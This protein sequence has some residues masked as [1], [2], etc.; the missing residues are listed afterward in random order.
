[1]RLMEKP[2]HNHVFPCDYHRVLSLLENH[3]LPVLGGQV[4]M[5][6]MNKKTGNTL[7][8]AYR[9]LCTL[10]GWMD[11]TGIGAEELI[12]LLQAVRK[13]QDEREAQLA[14][15]GKAVFEEGG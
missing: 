8:L 10:A 11:R 2:D 5:K 7:F 4:D 12:G 1:M 9:E 14:G 6:R 13:D 15:E 3:L